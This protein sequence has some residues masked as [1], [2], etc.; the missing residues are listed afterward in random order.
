[1]IEAIR[2]AAVVAAAARR[3]DRL[4]FRQAMPLEPH[5]AT[6]A[7]YSIPAA[8]AALERRCYCGFRVG[9]EN[10]AATA[11]RGDDDDVRGRKQRQ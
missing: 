7:T 9:V 5:R 11:P 1:V 6:L 2:L 3:G 8:A 10:G 4:R